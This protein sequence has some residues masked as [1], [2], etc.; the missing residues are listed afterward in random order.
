MVQ[1]F[2]MECEMNK[3]LRA[4]NLAI[5]QQWWGGPCWAQLGDAKTKGDHQSPSKRTAHSCTPKTDLAR[6]KTRG[7]Y[8][9]TKGDH[10]TKVPQ[11]EQHTPKTDLCTRQGRNKSTVRATNSAK[12]WNKSPLWGMNS[13]VQTRVV[14]R[15]YKSPSWGMNSRVQIR[16]VDSVYH[17][18]KV[19]SKVQKR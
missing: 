17:E 9:K 13:K 16:A 15:A 4:W 18:P 10:Q 8:A 7:H 5:K 2:A 6:A 1:S 11:W 12:S 14:D 19:R 3:H